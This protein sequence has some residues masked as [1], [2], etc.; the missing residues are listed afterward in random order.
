L[1]DRLDYSDKHIEILEEEKYRKIEY[2]DDDKRNTLT[3]LGGTTKL[4]D[5]SARIVK[6]DGA[7]HDE[8]VIYSSPGIEKQAAYQQKQ[9]FCA[10]P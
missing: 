1:Q 4:D 3:R 8:K 10:D 2:Y 6:K 9:I 5:I 7:H